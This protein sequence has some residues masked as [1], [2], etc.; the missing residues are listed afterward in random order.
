MAQPLK[1]ANPF[2]TDLDKTPANYEPLTP[3]AFLQ[4]TAWVFPNHTAVIHGPLRR[5]W[6][7]VHE[8]AHRLAGALSRRGLGMGDTVAVMLANTPEMLECHFGVPMTG[9]VL[10]TLNTRLDA[11]IIAFTLDHGEAKMIICDR[12]FSATVKEALSQIDRDIAVIDVDDPEYDGPGDLI[13]EKTYE[14]LLEEGDVGF[15][16]APPID[17]W[18]A[19]SLNYTSGTTGNPKGV[20][21]HHRG[22]Y[23]NA[24][25]N[26]LAWSMPMHPVYLWT[27]PMFHC[28]GWCFPWTI[29]MQAGTHVCLRQ[30]RA[31]AIYNAIAE[32]GVDHFCGAPIVLNMVV[33]AEESVKRPLGHTV[34][35]MTAAS[36]PP[37]TTLEKM[38]AAG[39]RITH[40]YGL[41][42]TYGPSVV[43]AWNDEWNA[44]SPSDQA[45]MKARQGVRYPMLEGLQVFDQDS[46]T[47]APADGETLGEVMM[48]GNVVMKGY[49]KN[50][51]ATE[52][53]FAGGWYHSGDLGVM[54]DDGYI[55][56]K[57]RSKDII[58]SGGENISSV[59]VEQ[60][61]YRHDAVAEAAVVA[62][63]DEKWGETPCAF[64]ELRPGV[65][66]PSAEDL[67]GFCR[68]N[69]AHYKCPRH[70]VFGPPAQDL[71]RQGAEIRAARA[72][73]GGLS[74]GA[75]R[76]RRRASFAAPS[77][78]D[79]SERPAPAGALELERR[80]V[81][82]RAFRQF[83]VQAGRDHPQVAA[84]RDNGRHTARP[85][86]IPH[87]LAGALNEGFHA[88]T[89]LGMVRPVQVVVGPPHGPAEAP[90]HNV[91]VDG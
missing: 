72:S 70:V 73:E 57:D 87:A 37:P 86:D 31:D 65:A 44:L 46:M 5:S 17:E 68:E 62:K 11:A 52:E 80:G 47:E 67:I 23:L 29:T 75:R 90:L 28:N 18:Q 48:R 12:E 71:H 8:R 42:E 79:E 26:A 45:A 35:I 77:L 14:A 56:L 54:H 7:E 82:D 13:G 40:A 16:Y 53:A 76:R 74:G 36:P 15:P 84:V 6:R 43:C 20:V 19:I 60:V 4:R 32:H 69:M 39:F 3:L 66:E 88:L 1:G 24:V 58:I 59:E 30:V 34:K 22:A 83:R 33:N 27:L 64:V 89:A 21:Y 10:N 78:G 85:A 25:S 81:G 49:L 55:A 63:P 51:T 38:E 61:L 9:A 91:E 41:T 50:P 2:E